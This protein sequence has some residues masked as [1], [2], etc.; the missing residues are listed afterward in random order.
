[1]NV[2]TCTGC[3][4]TKPLSEFFR[5][6]RHPNKYMP[7]CKACKA[8]NFRKW[9]KRN[10]DFDRKR[11]WA[12]REKELERHL[13]ATFGMTYDDYRSMLT[14]QNGQCAICKALPGA[15]RLDVDH[16]HTTKVIRGLLCSTCNRLIGYAKDSIETLVV[17]AEYLSSRKSRK[18]SGG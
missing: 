3:K 13:I 9:K 15:R 6:K 8:E 17:A 1:L 7:R 11:Y 12:N 16:C 2:Q 18:R 5:D 4:E 14:E 10:P